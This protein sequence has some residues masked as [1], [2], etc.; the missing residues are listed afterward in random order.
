[1]G[2]AK[3]APASSRRRYAGLGTR[4]SAPRGDRTAYA[5]RPRWCTT[6]TLGFLLSA[7]WALAAVSVL[8]V[9]GIAAAQTATEAPA[10]AG[11]VTS[12]TQ[13]DLSTRLTQS[14]PAYTREDTLTATVSVTNRRARPISY[15]EVRLRLRGPAGRL[16][17]QRTIVRSDVTGTVTYDFEK[18]L[19]DLKTTLKEGR[20][21]LEAR[22][23]AT[24]NDAIE[25]TDRL[26]VVDP[27]RPK[28][29][30]VVVARLTG[31]PMADPAGRFV[32]DPAANTASRDAATALSAA[33]ARMPALRMTL[34]IPPYMLEEWLRISNGYETVGPEG[35]RAVPATSRTS[36]S[37]GTALRQLAQAVRDPRVELTQVPYG[38][39]DLASLA[40]IGAISDLREHYARG[41]SIYRAALDATPSAGSVNATD[42]FPAASLPTMVQRRLRYAVVS[43]ASIVPPSEDT[44]PSGSYRIRGSAIVALVGDQTVSSSVS[45]T[46]GPDLTVLYDT[47]F[48]RRSADATPAPVVVVVPFGPG[49][50]GDVTRL[51]SMLDRAAKSGWV[52]VMTA[53]EAA[54]LPTT[55]PVTLESDIGR[56]TAPLG[57][58]EE[59]AQG[60]RLASAF[61]AAAGAADPEARTAVTDSLLSESYAW[62][63]PEGDWS[64]AD[65]GRAFAQAARR[66]SQ[67]TLGKVTLQTADVTLSGSGGR[68]PITIL[69]GSDKDLKVQVVASS[70]QLAFPKGPSVTTTVKPGE[71]FVTIPV[72]LGQALA[73]RVKVTVRAGGV[74][75]ASSSLNVQASFLNQLA[76]VAAIVA[77]LVGLLFFVRGRVRRYQSSSRAPQGRHRERESGPRD[78]EEVDD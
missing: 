43:P 72:D 1:V 56:R 39:P 5:R 48:G 14:A 68:L 74:D 11:P 25:L 66:T 44:T 50:A 27:E 13:T 12:V 51:T 70:P 10:Q 23:F 41:L 62:A 63:G 54:S 61:V 73:G 24:G 26:L 42:V 16:L 8:P 22:V 76:I 53:R 15:L 36:T 47:L 46:G 19:N 29:P 58:W 17:Y 9:T 60:R 77:V 38:T 40:R 2:P 28:V 7:A 57:Y 78:G 31:A 4:R 21:G 30:L 65:R 59:V 69:N 55:Q 18:P 64:L 35:V 33:L 6:T 49:V 34:A 71:S 52:R 20:F 37:Y 75:L 45:S 32:T 67:A 3:G